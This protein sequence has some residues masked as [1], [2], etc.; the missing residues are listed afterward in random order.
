MELIILLSLLLILYVVYTIFTR[1]TFVTKGETKM[2]KDIHDYYT[3]KN[4]G[5]QRWEDYRNSEKTFAKFKRGNSR[6]G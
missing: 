4:K 6:Y 1:E 5:G 3:R 2:N